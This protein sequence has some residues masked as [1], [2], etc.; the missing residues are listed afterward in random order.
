MG[1]DM[2]EQQLNDKIVQEPDAVRHILYIGTA[3][4]KGSIV[5]VLA[6]KFRAKNWDFN[7]HRDWHDGDLYIELKKL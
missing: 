4:P 3:Y 6:V 1:A 5:S 2:L 7:I